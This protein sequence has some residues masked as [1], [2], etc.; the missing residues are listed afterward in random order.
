MEKS[1]NILDSKDDIIS[2][3]DDE[4]IKELVKVKNGQVLKVDKSL[5]W[6]KYSR[7]ANREEMEEYV[8]EKYSENNIKRIFL[9]IDKI[10]NCAVCNSKMQKVVI[11]GVVVDMCEKHGFW[12]D[13][14]EILELLKGSNVDDG[15]VRFVTGLALGMSFR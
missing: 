12:L 15:S 8:K 7:E 3:L 6:H 10:K 13:K 5:F 9:E 1:M 14:G 4:K 11:K 2:V